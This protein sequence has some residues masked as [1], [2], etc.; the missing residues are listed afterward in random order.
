MVIVSIIVTSSTELALA[1]SSLDAQGIGLV[2][3]AAAN[4]LQRACG[5]QE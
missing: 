3:V 4:L 2:L 1:T 5:P